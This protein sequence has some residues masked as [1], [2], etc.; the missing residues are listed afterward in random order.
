MVYMDCIF[1]KIIAGEIPSKKVYEDDICYAFADIAPQALVHIILVPKKHI[2]S[3]SQAQVADQT[4]LGHLMLAAAKI[5]RIAGV[6]EG[7]YRVLTNIGKDGGQTVFHLHI[8][9]MGGEVL[10]PLN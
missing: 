1:C 5:A 7:G 10:G 4:L 9:V 2:E 3:L 6:D 8:H